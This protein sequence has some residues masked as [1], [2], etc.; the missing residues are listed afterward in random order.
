MTKIE[1]NTACAKRG[2]PSFNDTIRV[3][4][5]ELTCPDGYEP[6]SAFTSPTETV[7]WPIGKD[8]SDCPIIDI[9][10]VSGKQDES[11]YEQ[12]GYRLTSQGFNIDKQESTTTTTTR[13]AFSQT[14]S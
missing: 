6:C 9:I 14:S 4:P 12:L 1:E 10:F 8:K 2:G 3:N 11:K 13:I 5:F 7:C